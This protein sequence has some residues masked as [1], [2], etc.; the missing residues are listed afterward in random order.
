MLHLPSA[1][2]ADAIAAEWAA[3]GHAIEPHKLILLLASG[4][5]LTDDEM[6]KLHVRHMVGGR[7]AGVAN[8]RLF[9]FEFPERPGALHDFLDAIGS[10]WNITLFHYRNHGSDYGRVLAGI[11]VSPADRE[12]L[13]RHLEALGYPHEEESDNPA[14]AMF[15]A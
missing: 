11:D 3:Q 12:E 14:Y 15:L 10:D 9:R 6:A 13:E 5:P 7:A 8:E 1:A 4:V 2:L